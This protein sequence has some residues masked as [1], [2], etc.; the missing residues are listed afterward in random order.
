MVFLGTPSALHLHPSPYAYSQVLLFRILYQKI[1]AIENIII[2]KT[3][4]RIAKIH[5]TVVAEGFIFSF[6]LEKR[7][8]SFTNISMI[9]SLNI[10]EIKEKK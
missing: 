4:S 8:V 1:A 6:P 9:S 7:R 2:K 3:N 5:T 10:T